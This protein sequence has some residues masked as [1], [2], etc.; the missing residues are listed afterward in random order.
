MEKSVKLKTIDGKG[1]RI[2]PFFHIGV[3]LHL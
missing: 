2:A 3:I 1:Q